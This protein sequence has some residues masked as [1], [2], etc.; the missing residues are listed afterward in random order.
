ML[1]FHSDNIV[2]VEKDHDAM[3]PRQFFTIAAVCIL[4]TWHAAM[5]VAGDQLSRGTQIVLS[6]GLQLAAVECKPTAYFDVDRWL[7]A[8]FTVINFQSSSYPHSIL[9]AHYLPVTQQWGRW[10]WD[11]SRTLDPADLPY[12]SNCVTLQYNDE[13]DGNYG[14]LNILDPS[15]QAAVA[16]QFSTWN[17]LYPNAMTDTSFYGGQLTSS[18]LRTYVMTCKPDLLTYESFPGF[19]ATKQAWYAEMQKYRQVALAGYDGTGNQ[20]IPYAQQTQASRTSYSDPLPGESFVRWQQFASWA[21]GFTGVTQWVYG[22]PHFYN[23]TPGQ[24]QILPQ[25]FSTP[26]YDS[27][28]IMFGYVAET[29]RQSQHLGPA[30][31][32]MVSTNAHYPR[33]SQWRS[34]SADLQCLDL[35]PRRRED[36][37]LH[38]LYHRHYAA[39]KRPRPPECDGL[40]RRAGGL[41]Q[42]VALRQQRRDVRRWTAFHDRQRK[43]G[44]HDVHGQLQPTV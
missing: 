5:N 25:M 12:A 20:P 31:V 35:D 6:R 18:Q 28:T 30:L 24:D 36:G 16:A 15:T 34:Q 38:G 42:A 7:S 3:K 14:K 41:L 8:N 23:P 11:D 19:F 13:M 17:A 22:D 26:E 33:Q 29:N 4:L 2:I 1:K 37:R 27:P 43:C 32:R 44:W 10:T 39:G 9:L 21:F 40:Q